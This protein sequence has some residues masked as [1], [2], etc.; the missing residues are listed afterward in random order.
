M[1][2]LTPVSVAAMAVIF[3]VIAIVFVVNIRKE[4]K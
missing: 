3:I 1:I 4:L 2:E